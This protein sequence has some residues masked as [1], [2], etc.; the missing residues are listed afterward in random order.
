M[1]DIK[2]F[3]INGLP[4]SGKHSFVYKIGAYKQN[5]TYIDANFPLI[6]IASKMHIDTSSM[7]Y[8]MFL[9]QLKALWGLYN[10]EHYTRF[11]DFVEEELDE[12]S[13]YLVSSVLF[14]E[15]NNRADID[16]TKLILSTLG[17][18]VKTILIRRDGVEFPQIL[19]HYD[20]SDNYN[21]IV[22][23]NK[24]IKDLERKAMEFKRKFINRNRKKD[25]TII[26]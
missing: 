26:F 12:R 22:D 10:D 9:L 6:E 19:S 11:I 5:V 16:K 8:T 7:T 2:I 13:N 1:T 4:T 17:Y 25:D 14:L 24:S 21:V 23:N 3:I 20:L 18:E 15:I